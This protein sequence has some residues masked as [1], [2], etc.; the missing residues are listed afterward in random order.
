MDNISLAHYLMAGQTRTPGH[1]ESHGEHINA[2][3]SGPVLVL[4]PG[5]LAARQQC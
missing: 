1:T 2:T 4:Y 5:H 3:M